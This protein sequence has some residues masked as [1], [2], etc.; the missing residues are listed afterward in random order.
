MLNKFYG[1][2]VKTEQS[3]QMCETEGGGQLLSHFQTTL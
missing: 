2:V 1:L 3:L